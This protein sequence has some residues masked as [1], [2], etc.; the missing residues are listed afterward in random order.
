MGHHFVM[1]KKIVFP[2]VS[3]VTSLEADGPARKEGWEGAKLL[4]ACPCLARCFSGELG[5]FKSMEEI[6]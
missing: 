6:P 4:T 3:T 5:A 1:L 2:C